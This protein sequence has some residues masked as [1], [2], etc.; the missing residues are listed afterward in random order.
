MDTA[1]FKN[2]IRIQRPYRI[3]LHAHTYPVSQCSEV[4]PQELV[5]A[6]ANRGYHGVV[7]TNHFIPGLLA[8]K[9]ADAL[10]YYLRDYENALAAGEKYGVAVY[11]GAELRFTEN[12]NDY[13][14][15]GVDEDI[16]RTAFEYLDKGVEVYRR[17]V[18]LPN[19]VFL[20]AHP[21]RNGM[22]L[23]DPAFLDGIEC[24]NLHPGHNSRVGIAT[25]YAYENHLPIKTAGTDHHHPTHEGL[26]VLRTQTLPKDSFELA[27]I[28][29]N[30][31]L[32]FEIGENSFWIP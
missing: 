17:E 24:F 6:Y 8:M 26:S 9:P 16:L 22:V 18:Q 5:Q 25:R 12:P 29:K 2:E 27:Q 7:L 14:L 19:S 30:G 13:L 1:S 31:D 20:Q 4:Q 32:V 15:F 3:E 28:L 11:L 10:D 23:C 21:F